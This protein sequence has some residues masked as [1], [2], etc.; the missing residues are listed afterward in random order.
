MYL[1]YDI[2]TDKELASCRSQSNLSRDVLYEL[3]GGRSVIRISSDAVIKCGFG[4]TQEEAT[5]QI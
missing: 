4:V 5:N 2:A 1:Q 3:H